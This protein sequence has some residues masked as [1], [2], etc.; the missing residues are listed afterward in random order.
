MPPRE[1]DG[2]C[3]LGHAPLVVAAEVERSSEPTEQPDGQLRARV[4]DRRACLFEQLDRPLVGDA[5]APARVLVSDG[6]PA[7]QLGV[8]ELAG[9][10]RRRGERVER[11]QR[12]PRPVAGGSNLQQHRRALGGA[13]DPELEGGTQPRGGLVE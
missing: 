9:N 8:P 6:A 2:P 13:L 10:A 5:R 4:V 3:A 1:L 7:E 11:V 12:L